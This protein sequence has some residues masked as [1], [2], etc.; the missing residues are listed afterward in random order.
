MSVKTDIFNT[1]PWNRCDSKLSA[2]G[3][4]RPDR[5]GGVK[6]SWLLEGFWEDKRLLLEVL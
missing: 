5:A 2:L 4:S 1:R 3:G 6:Q